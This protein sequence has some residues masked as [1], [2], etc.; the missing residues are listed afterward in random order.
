MA[1]D[2]DLPEACGLHHACQIVNVIGQAVAAAGRPVGLAVPAEVGRDDMKIRPQRLRRM[3]PAAGVIE[4]AVNEDQRRGRWV[5]P[6]GEV[7]PKPLGL[8]IACLLY[9]S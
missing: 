5:T 3:I 1:D 8:I 9:T 4:T 6:I 7:K 2:G